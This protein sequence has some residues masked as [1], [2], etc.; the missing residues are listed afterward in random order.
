M[1][2]YNR[3]EIGREFPFVQV[4]ELYAPAMIIMQI[5]K[6]LSLSVSAATLPNPTEV[7]QVM[8]KYKAVTYMVFLEG[9]LIS[10]GVLLD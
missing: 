4:P 10:S 9:P 5:V 6:I 3:A 7:I 2:A 1:V 8:V